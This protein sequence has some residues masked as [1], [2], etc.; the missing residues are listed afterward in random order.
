MNGLEPPRR[1]RITHPRTDAVRRA[2]VRPASREIDEQT[3]LGEVYM[4]SLIRAQ[5]RLGFVVCATVAVLLFGTALLGALSP[6]FV[7]A[8][9]LG[10]PLPWLLLGIVIYPVLIALAR[11]TTRQAERN[12]RAF[13]D[14]MR[15]Q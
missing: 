10:M 15:R 6:R 9:V 12:E 1:T 7:S 11:Y 4:S 14:L 13:S 3:G 2:P 8:R 5:R